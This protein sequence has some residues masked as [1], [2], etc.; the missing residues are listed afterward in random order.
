VKL[1]KFIEDENNLFETQF[2]A[3]VRDIAALESRLT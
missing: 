3:R 1:Q 2:D